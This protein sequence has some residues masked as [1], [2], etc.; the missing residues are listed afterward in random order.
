[1]AMILL[2]AARDEASAEALARACERR[3]MFVEVETGRRAGRP[4]KPE[5]HCVAVLSKAEASDGLA[6]ARRKR[7][8]DASTQAKLSLLPLEEG[9]HV[10]FGWRDLARFAP[11]ELGGAWGELAGRLQAIAPVTAPVPAFVEAHPEQK[12]S[13]LMGLGVPLRRVA[14]IGCKSTQVEA[15]SLR[16]AL[17]LRGMRG[18]IAAAEAPGSQI[19]ALLADMD[20][21]AIL[22]SAEA[23]ASDGMRR[24][25]YAAGRLGMP[26]LG[27]MVD[28]LWRD[29][30]LADHLGKIILLP[31]H[32]LAGERRGG[33]LAARCRA[34][35]RRRKSQGRA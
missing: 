1:M 20:M 30:P 26:A 12:R 5:D 6:L 9:L 3:G 34:L 11:P 31:L 13:A 18:T 32:R 21:A 7:G 29:A 16:E 15:D 2:H 14:L 10:P 24:W 22:L 35:P 25:L 4:F 23:G 8:F 33:Q 27:V 19:S 17:L 28:E